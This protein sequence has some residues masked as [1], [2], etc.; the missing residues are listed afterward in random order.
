MFRADIGIREDKIVQVG[1]LHNEK[2]EVEIDATE[3]TGVSGVY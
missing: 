1:E 2:G 3:Q